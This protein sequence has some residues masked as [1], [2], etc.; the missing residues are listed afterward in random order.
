[1]MRM[2]ALVETYMTSVERLSHYAKRLESEETI[3]ARALLP[4]PTTTTM[5]TED[6]QGMT[7]SSS[8]SSLVQQTTSTTTSSNNPLANDDWTP[9]DGKVELVDLRVRY[10]C[11]LPQVVTGVN[12]TIEPGS[13][14]G[15]VGRTG[16]GKSSLLLAL[17]RLN[18]VSQ[19]VKVVS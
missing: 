14:V 3:L 2:S 10:R 13:K 17:S 6:R 19:S 16:S 7:S 9:C 8:S 11:D 1:M 5:P 12:A 4:P 15:V 18:E